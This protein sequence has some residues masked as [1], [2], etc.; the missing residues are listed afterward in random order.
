MPRFFVDKTD[1]SATEILLRDT[2]HLKARR[3]RAGDEL[4]V[5]DG[6]GTD[7]SVRLIDIEKDSARAEILSRAPSRTEADVE[8]A[9]FLAFSK[10]ER[11]EFAIQKCTE[12]GASAFFLFPSERVVAMPDGK[13]LANR[14]ARLGNIARSAAE[15]S[16]R[17][18]IPT[19][20]AC[21]S[22]A[23]ATAQAATAALPLLCYE[24]EEKTSLRD[25][26]ATSPAPP[27]ISIMTGAEGG[28]SPAEAAYAVE[29]GLRSVTLGAR[30]L[31][32]DTAPIATTAAIML[33]TGNL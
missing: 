17:G 32:C 19:V 14:L 1:I 24:N 30:I 2:A 16:E 23:A 5:C 29:N 31:R 20:S 25:I 6:D 27:S 9:V 8:L 10:G 28:F 26:F 12:L 22:F 13:S 7:F 11:A 4:T 18:R 15:Q 21:T 33:L 3:L